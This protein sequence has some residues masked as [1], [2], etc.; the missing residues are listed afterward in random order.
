MNA[1]QHHVVFVPGKNPKPAAS[2]HREILWRCIS[3]GARGGE[4]APSADISSLHDRFHIADWN[5][6][7]YGSEADVGID[8]PWVARMLMGLTATPMTRHDR[9]RIARTRWIFTLGDLIPLFTQ[10]FADA[11]ARQ[12]LAETRRYFDD[13]DGIATRIRERVKEVLQPLFEAGCEVMIVGH[14]LGSVIAYETL[15]ELC[16]RDDEPWRVDQLLTLGSPLGMFYVQRRLRGHDERGLRRYPANIRH[17]SNISAEGDL[18]ALDR[19]LRNDFHGMLDLGMVEDI[20]DHTHGVHTYFH[21]DDGPNPHRCYGYFFNPAVAR[22][23]TAWMR[24]ERY[25]DGAPA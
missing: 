14:S 5:R 25:P 13:E 19:G 15:W 7:Y 4:L 10:L 24:G 8:L 18:I 21:T 22:R 3:A 11:D 9:W 16:W 17:W 6:L 12:T 20:V 1:P 2:V 23:I